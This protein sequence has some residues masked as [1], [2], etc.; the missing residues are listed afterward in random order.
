MAAAVAGSA[1]LVVPVSNEDVSIQRIV[2]VRYKDHV[3]FKN[4][5][6]VG[7]S[8]VIRETIG[9][10]KKENDDLVLIENDRSILAGCSGFNGILILKN[11]ILSMVEVP[12]QT[13]SYWDLNCGTDTK[14]AEYALQTTERKTLKNRREQ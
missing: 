9:W 4:V 13:I 7:L 11:C 14:R 5:Q 3:V 12:L 8:P 6:S 10:I 1:S 2:F